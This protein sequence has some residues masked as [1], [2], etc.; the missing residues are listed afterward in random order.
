M[1]VLLAAMK[2]CNFMDIYTSDLP[3]N[4]TVSVWYTQDTL[5]V[6]IMD[7][8]VK[9]LVIFVENFYVFSNLPS[10]MCQ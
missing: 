1:Y 7:F 6:E 9:T 10:Q 4:G 8:Y 5:C 2:M 3:D